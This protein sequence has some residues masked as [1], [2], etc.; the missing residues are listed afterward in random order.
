[1]P[2]ITVVEGDITTLQV[3]AI[4]NAANTR[5]Q[6]GGGVALAI[7][8]VGG[9]VIQR[10]SDDWIREH[11]RLSS[12]VAAVTPAGTMPSKIVVHVAGPRFTEGQDNESLLR[13]A[14]AAALDAVA[15]E[16]CRT[17]AFPAISAGVYGYPLL[18][19]T[20][21]IATTVRKW[22]GEHPTTLDKVLLVGHDTTTAMAFEAA[23][24]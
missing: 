19:A 16:E 22:T 20:R 21:V 4:V 3:D 6:H 9:P 11:G 1:M 7:A 5:L 23:L 13:T 10:A 14:V 15:V 12:G 8:Q 24:D 17:V 18:E 2:L